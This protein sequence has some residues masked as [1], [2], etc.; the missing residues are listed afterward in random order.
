MSHYYDNH[1]YTQEQAGHAVKVVLDLIQQHRFFLHVPK[2]GDHYKRDYSLHPE[3]FLEPLT[4]NRSL[5]A[6]YET[7]RAN[8]GTKILEGEAALGIKSPNLLNNR[9][10]V[11]CNRYNGGFEICRVYPF[12]VFASLA[13]KDKNDLFKEHFAWSVHGVSL[14]E[15]APKKM[16][17][18]KEQAEFVANQIWQEFEELEVSDPGN[19]RCMIL[20]E[21][22]V[23]CSGCDES[24]DFAESC[25]RDLQKTPFAVGYLFWKSSQQTRIVPHNYVVFETSKESHVLV[26]HWAGRRPTIE[27]TATGGYDCS[28]CFATVL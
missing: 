14:D 28:V 23:S 1:V 21:S 7:V 12:T 19:C 20:F 2:E 8:A 15:I 4:L 13:P 11:V 17:E 26:E 18:Y 22:R 6:L 24:G 27:Y 9:Q 5:R 3:V 10:L 16:R 25:V